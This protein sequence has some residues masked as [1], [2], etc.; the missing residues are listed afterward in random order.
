MGETPSDVLALRL[1]PNARI[2][3]PIIY[4]TNLFIS[5]SS[6]FFIFHKTAAMAFLRGK[7]WL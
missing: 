3:I 6:L 7:P 1:I 5:I 2:T 4:K